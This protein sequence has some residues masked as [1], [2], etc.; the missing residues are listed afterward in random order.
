M[1]IPEIRKNVA[2]WSAHWKTITRDGC[3]DNCNLSCCFPNT[4]VYS[5]R[6]KIH[7]LHTIIYNTCNIQTL[8]WLENLYSVIL[9]G[10]VAHTMDLYAKHNFSY[11]AAHCFVCALFIA[12]PNIQEV[13]H[14]GRTAVSDHL[15]MDE[16]CVLVRKKL[17]LQN[18]I[19]IFIITLLFLELIAIKFPNC[20]FS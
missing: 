10:E 5:L 15:H 6:M 9:C 1:F 2:P 13:I 18:H 11:A 8:Q 16:L 14:C 20:D 4:I 19:V 17:Q 12:C 7:T 3:S